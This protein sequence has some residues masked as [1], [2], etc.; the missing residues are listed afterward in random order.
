MRALEAPRGLWITGLNNRQ[1]HSLFFLAIVPVCVLFF[2]Y[3]SLVFLSMITELAG[4]SGL[5][6][7]LVKSKP[8]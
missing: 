3:I 5:W 6:V 2:L 7:G 4:L 8:T 1:A